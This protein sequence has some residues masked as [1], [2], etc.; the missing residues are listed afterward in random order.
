MSEFMKQK[1]MG[2]IEVLYNHNFLRKNLSIH[3]IPDS[4]SKSPI[5]GKSHFYV[6]G[7][8]DTKSVFVEKLVSHQSS[9]QSD[10]PF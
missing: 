9:P 10:D 3:V 4:F 1:A 7:R 6:K 8:S 5:H 2:L